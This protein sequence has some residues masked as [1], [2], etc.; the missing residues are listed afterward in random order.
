MPSINDAGRFPA[1]RRG[2]CACLLSL[3]LGVGAAGA[4]PAPGLVVRQLAFEGNDAIPGEVLA[5]GIS[6]TNSSWFARNIFV[7]W[8]QNRFDTKEGDFINNRPQV[9]PGFPPLGETLFGF[10][11]CSAAIPGSA[12]SERHRDV[13][14]HRYKAKDIE[15]Q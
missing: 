12:C 13:R 3:P 2:L 6:T 9:Y 5:S 11:A 7:R 1:L 15:F 10:R 8:L 14:R 4:Q